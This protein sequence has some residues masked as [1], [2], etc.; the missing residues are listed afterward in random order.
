MLIDV[1]ERYRDRFPFDPDAQVLQCSV[2]GT[3]LRPGQ[4]HHALRPTP[5]RALNALIV[6]E[7]PD[8]T[9]SRDGSHGW[10]DSE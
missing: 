4:P 9:A 7:H 10:L 1:S 2:C 3:L 8:D 6:R 5:H